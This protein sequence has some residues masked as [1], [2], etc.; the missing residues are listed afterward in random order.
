MNVSP[1]ASRNA[2][3]VA[4]VLGAACAFGADARAE[5]VANP[6]L[7]TSANIATS[8]APRAADASGVA[9]MLADPEKIFT[10]AKAL[11]RA[12]SDVPFVSYSLLE[13][14]TWRDRVHDN[15]WQASYR[16]RDRALALRR[17][18]VAEQEQQR[19]KGSAIGLI[20]GHRARARADSLD[21]NPDADAFPILDPLIEPDASFGLVRRA[22]EASLAD[23]R[24]PSQLQA[25]LNAAAL[26]VPTAV[27]APTPTA[28]PSS[29]ASSDA[30]LREV[31]RVEAVA[32]DY[33]IALAGTEHLRYGDAY[34]LTLEPL[35]DPKR[36]RLRDLW[37][38]TDSFAVERIVLDGLFDGKPYDGARWTIDY[39]PIGDR[40]YVQ[41]IKTGETLRFGLDRY[42]SGLEFDFVQYE[43]PK[44]VPGITFEKYAF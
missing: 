19:L 1:K 27:P 33:R 6:P 41:Q 42:V 30:V 31:G 4:F 34:H 13:R 2:R 8:T 14:Y 39:L 26:A 22:G 44:D 28:V 20:I 32:R 29:A 17:T 35:H 7:A 5:P 12:R 3:I 15:W 40:W 37:V 18:I 21:T 38:A 24:M 16:T 25:S 11:W 43:F 10:R 36:Y 23:G 9:T